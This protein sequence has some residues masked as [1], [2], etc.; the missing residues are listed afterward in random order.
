MH[1]SLH[2]H[3]LHY[4]FGIPPTRT[5]GGILFFTTSVNTFCLFDDW[6]KRA[7]TLNVG[8]VNPIIWRNFK[9]RYQISCIGTT[10][11]AICCHPNFSCTDEATRYWRIVICVWQIR[12]HGSLS[13]SVRE[14]AFSKHKLSSVPKIKE[15]KLFTNLPPNL[16]ST[17]L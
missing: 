6:W 5:D 15:K 13:E 16:I 3:G 17:F 9:W 14:S 11:N 1:I 12:W 7:D 4:D 10:A 2:K 8:E